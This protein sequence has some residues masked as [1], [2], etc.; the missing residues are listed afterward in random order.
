V[1]APGGRGMTCSAA[2]AAETFDQ[3]DAP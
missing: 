1:T 2:I 3:L